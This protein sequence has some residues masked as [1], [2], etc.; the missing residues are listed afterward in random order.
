MIIKT[1]QFLIALLT[2]FILSGCAMNSETSSVNIETTPVNSEATIKT[3]EVVQRLKFNVVISDEP[4]LTRVPQEE[5]G[6]TEIGYVIYDS[7]REVNLVWNDK[8]KSFPDVI[9]EKN[10]TIPEIF[11][12]AHIDAQNGFCEE[13]FVSSQGLAHFCYT[14]PECELWITYDIYETPDGE[15]NLIN[16]IHICNVDNVQQP[17]V[18]T[19]VDYDSQWGYFL[20][21]EDWGL[22][23]EVISILPTQITVSYTQHQAQEIGELSVTDY[24]LY[25]RSKLDSPDEYLGRINYARD[26]QPIFLKSDG[27]SQIVF[28]WSDI[29]GTLEPGDYYIKITVVDNYDE[30][31]I[32]PLMKN[33]Y[34]RQSYHIVFSIA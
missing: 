24:S 23:F 25:S 6:D 17:L 12:F 2:I 29:A 27:S 15:Q 18:T 5:L 19:Y 32:H 26:T 9:R 7:F 22:D 21:R 31:S 20:D 1:H 28:D 11:A 16:E 8:L 33:Y 14:Y 34:D 4:S 10:L 30:L 13:T 3:D